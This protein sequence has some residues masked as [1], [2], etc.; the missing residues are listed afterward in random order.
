M[1]RSL[2]RSLARCACALFLLAALNLGSMLKAQ[3]LPIVYAVEAQPLKSQAK[4]VAQALEFLGQPLTAAEQQQ[5]DAALASK[6]IC[7]ARERN[8]I[9]ATSKISQAAALA[10]IKYR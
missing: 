2:S 8:S 5:L 4:R 6:G 1:R 10:P 9:Q 3:E 7:H